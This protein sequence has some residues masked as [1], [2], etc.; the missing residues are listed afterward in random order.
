MASVADLRANLLAAIAIFPGPP[1]RL[2][3]DLRLDIE[4]ISAGATRFALSVFLAGESSKSSN[5]TRQVALV[6]LSFLH[7]LAS[8]TNERAYTEGALDTMLASLT[9]ATW[10]RALASVYALV[11]GALPE[12]EIER[13]GNAVRVGLIV[14]LAL[15]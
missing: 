14:Q 1:T 11:D 4:H 9:S 15:K 2:A 5:E 3:S 12:I 8:G 6:Q 10:W 13:V 7:R